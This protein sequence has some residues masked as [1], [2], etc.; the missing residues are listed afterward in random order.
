MAEAAKDRRS[1][2]QLGVLIPGAIDEMHTD[3]SDG[4][5]AALETIEEDDLPYV[6]HFERDQRQHAP[7]D[8]RGHED[9]L[10]REDGQQRGPGH[11]A[12]GIDDEVGGGEVIVVLTLEAEAFFHTADIGRSVTCPAEPE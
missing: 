10:G 2:S 1:R 7:C 3:I 11:L 6:L 8:V 5:E 4:R 12:D 9:V